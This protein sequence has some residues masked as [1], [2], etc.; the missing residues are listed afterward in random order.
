MRRLTDKEYIDIY[1]KVPRVC[2]DL[3]IMVG[4]HF[5]LEKRDTEPYLGMWGLI[6]GGVSFGET[7]EKAIQRHALDGLG[8]S[9]SVIRCL[10]IKEYLGNDGWRHSV[11]LNYLVKPVNDIINPKAK[12]FISLPDNTLPTHAELLKEWRF[13]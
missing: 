7:L 11:S 12:M 8:V 13:V 6:G 2:V 5:V 9:V 1:S 10:G 4:N 3:I